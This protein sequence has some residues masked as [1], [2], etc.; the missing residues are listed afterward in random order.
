MPTP[1]LAA[2]LG[3]GSVLSILGPT[4]VTPPATPTP[5]GELTGEPKFEGW[6][7]GLTT[8]T[9]FD[10][11]NVV[12][13]LGT[14]LDYGSFTSDYNYISSNA[15]QLLLITALKSGVSYDFTLQ[16]PKQPLLGQTTSGNLYAMSGVVTE[17]G[18]FGISQDKTSSSSLSIKLNSITF[19]AGS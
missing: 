19:T 4:G 16:L 5:I 9:N 11:G 7:M 12:Q 8:N 17:A 15:G 10:S 14:L 6:K 2:V 3:T 18:G 1:S 13:S